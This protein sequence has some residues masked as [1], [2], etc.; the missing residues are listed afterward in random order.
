MK[1]LRQLLGKKAEPETLESQIKNL[2]GQPQAALEAIV[3]ADGQHIE[4]R[5]SALELIVYGSF[6][7][8]LAEGEA[9]PELQKLARQKIAQQVDEGALSVESLKKSIKSTDALLAISSFCAKVDLET[10]ILAG[11]DDQALLTDLCHKASSSSV[12]QRLANRISETELLKELAKSLKAKDKKAYKIVKAKLDTAKEEEQ[13]AREIESKINELSQ[14]IEQNRNR[15]VDR[16]YVLRV[17]RLDRRWREISDHATADVRERFQSSLEFCNDKI[18]SYE[19]ELKAAEAFKD[20]VSGAGSNR[21]KILEKVWHL[22]GDIYDLEQVDE[23]QISEFLEQCESLKQ[24]WRELK[25]YGKPSSAEA[26][27]YTNMFDAVDSLISTYKDNGCLFQS[28]VF[29]EQAQSDIDLAER[30]SHIKL[31]RKLLYPIQSLSAYESP[32]NA[33]R[34]VEVL[35]KVDADYANRREDRQK[36]IRHIGGLLRK[37]LAAAGQ[38]R[39]RQAIGI[40]H[41]I[42]EKC[43]EL[44]ALPSNLSRQLEDLDVAVE[45][46]VDWQAYAVV[47]KKKALIESM[48][49]LVGID[50]PPEALATKIKN[51]QD[52]WKSLSQSGKDRQE[53]L[54]QK[55]SELADK[56][57]EPCKI[58]YQDLAE[59]RKQNLEK[60]QLLVKQLEDFYS[61]YTWDSADWKH[62]ESILS[63]ARSELHGYAPVDRSAN[64]PVLAA[65]DKAI[66]SIKEKL[67][68]ELNKNK[69]AKERLIQQAEKL[70]DIADIQQAIDSAKRL[71][72]QWKSIGRCHYRDND[73]LWKAFRGHCDTVFDKKQQQYEARK[74]EVDAIV[75]KAKAVL[76]NMEMMVNLPTEELFSKR[77]ERDELQKEFS[78][79]DGLPEKVQRGIER[80]LKKAV[81]AI[82]TKLNAA[83]RDKE[84]NAWRSYFDVCEKINAYCC[85]FQENDSDQSAKRTEL[86]EFIASVDQWPDGCFNLIKQRM[87]AQDF[88]VKEDNLKALKI[89][90][91]RVEILSE[92]ETPEQDKSLRME[93][94]V[95]M[96]KKG[97]GTVIQEENVAAS[98][99]KE[100]GQAG[101]VSQEDYASVFKRFHENWSRLP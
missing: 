13:K 42:E 73:K 46:L 2:H 40:R 74:A 87:A 35:E 3:N 26:K 61:D 17:D 39:L 29:F 45:K 49:S 72:M 21:Q 51:L 97:I 31:L 94:Q 20:K 90:C 28:L 32:K 19:A 81:D 44:D 24:E 69:A 85:D 67:E 65:F 33:K 93:Y 50:V 82:E 76:Q 18:Q 75:A 86:D 77:A 30:E 99:A 38:G 10:E 70:A 83:K 11:I 89:L 59:Q 52:Q 1:L 37:G 48:E 66:A 79:I 92:K 41:S 91:I 63:T 101:P 55:F 57:Y 5:K 43:K 53:E 80:D 95:N 15:H 56:A 47:P 8:R 100:W 54:W 60:R 23:E 25:Q 16:D 96:L 58:Y 71:Q 36:Q 6:V 68:E 78:Q 34:A 27:D 88:E 12:R 22:I 98:I 84:A 62:V 9:A 4:I 7:E 64:K 14:E